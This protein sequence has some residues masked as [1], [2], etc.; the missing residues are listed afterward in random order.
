VLLVDTYDTRAGV[1]KVIDLAREL[2]SAFKGRAIRLDSGDL[3]ALS[4]EARALL[5]A[6]GL[7]SV[8]IFASGGLNEEKIAALVAAGAPIDGFGVGTDLVVSTDAPAFDI[9]YKLTEYGGE[10]RLKL[11]TGKR[12]LPGRKQI[13]RQ[14][15]DGGIS[16]VIARHD[17]ALPGAPLMTQVMQRGA[18]LAPA[19][20]LEAVQARCRERIAGLPAA[21]RALAPAAPFQ[22][23][24][25]AALSALEQEV[26]RRVAAS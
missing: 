23:Q 15:R 11:S 9:V 14:L 26:A 1:A 10:G 6:A 2:G 24:V 13:F 20:S 5:D 12:T 21:L 22:P 8:G 19:A 7:S 17:E 3:A 25:S 4:R 16:D 18:R